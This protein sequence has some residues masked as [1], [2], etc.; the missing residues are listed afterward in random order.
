[1][2]RVEVGNACPAS[3]VSCGKGVRMIQIGVSPGDGLYFWEFAAGESR[4]DGTLYRGDIHSMPDVMGDIGGGERTETDLERSEELEKETVL[5]GPGQIIYDPLHSG[6]I[7]TKGALRNPVP[8]PSIPRSL[9]TSAGLGA[10]VG[11]FVPPWPHGG[12]R[13]ILPTGPNFP[14]ALLVGPMP[15][16]AP[17][18]PSRGA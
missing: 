11:G 15:M 7:R 14:R 17:S 12:C 3:S 18:G 4:W 2:S 16:A 10:A 1:M 13:R 5:C 8:I 6:T 9:R